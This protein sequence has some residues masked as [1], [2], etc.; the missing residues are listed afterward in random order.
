[1][2]GTSYYLDWPYLNIFNSIRALME[3]LFKNIYNFSYQTHAQTVKVSWQSE[4]VYAA[5]NLAFCNNAE[6]PTKSLLIF[7]NC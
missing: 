1:M 3:L 6:M 2:K 5:C 7:T 4:L